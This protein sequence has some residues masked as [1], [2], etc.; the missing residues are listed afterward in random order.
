MKI[1]ILNLLIGLIVITG[2]SMELE[3]G[4]PTFDVSV[5]STTVKAGQAIDFT[6]SGQTDN[7]YF[8]SG[9][10]LKDYAFKDG[11]VI[12]VAASGATVS[13]T[14]SVT[15]GTQQ[16]QLSVLYST[17]FNGDYNDLASVKAATW[18]DITSN[19]VLG[20]SATFLAS[21]S[22][23]IS[24]V[25]IAGK[26]IYFAFKYITRPQ[27]ANGF[28]RTWMIQNFTVLSKEKLGP[29][30]LTVCDQLYAGFRIIDENP[31]NAPARSVL[32]T[33]RVTLLGNIY[34]DPVDPV[35]DPNNPIY[36]PQS[37]L[38][39]PNAVYV[40]YDYNS[41]YNDLMSENWAVSA[42]IYV[43][44]VSLGPDKPTPIKSKETQ[45]EGYSYTYST[46]GTYQAYF[47][48]SNSSIDFV[49]QVVK[50]FEFV[51]TE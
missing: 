32:T 1:K 16:N 19:F 21:G 35:Y 46:P 28:V 3:V 4:E 38:Y 48:A 23:D 26:P 7:I 47:I 51:V 6:F 44:K 31:E 20:T 15:G 13:F 42:P 36:D 2:C 40:P 33:S 9:E 34:K 24:D 50:K 17:N 12:Q 25:I 37:P 30:N 5:V 45:S 10:L 22:F 43:D 39:N 8:Y 27:V 18:V 41:P 49:K 29:T 11:R 14:S